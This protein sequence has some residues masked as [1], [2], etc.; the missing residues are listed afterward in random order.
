MVDISKDP[1][2]NEKER[3]RIVNVI[4]PKLKRAGVAIHTI[5]LSKNADH[6]LLKQL[7]TQTDG[8]YQEV[9][10]ADE[11]Q[12][13]FLK[14]FEQA[15]QR[16]A[17][18][19]IDNQFPVD[20]S[21]DEMT[22]LVFRQTD[23]APTRLI[24]PSDKVYDS[25][26]SD[27]KIRWFAT[28][29]Y[30]LI[31]IEKP[32]T[33]NWSIDAKV[34]PDNRVMVVSKLGLSIK[35]LPNNL[36]AGEAIDYQLQLLEEGK[37][38]KNTDFLNLV[39]AILVQDKAGQSS[40]L[41]M[42]YDTTSKTFKQNFFTDS[43]EGELKLTLKV[44]SPTFERERTH[45]INIYGSPIDAEV[46]L[47]E[48]NILPHQLKISAKEDIVD[49]SSLKISLTITQPSGIKKFHVI[50]EA[51]SLTEIAAEVKGGHYK[52]D[53]KIAG[54]SQLGRE[55]SVT[56]ESLEF[57]V[58]GSATEVVEQAVAEPISQSAPAESS[59]KVTQEVPELEPQQTE[60]EQAAE[61]SE[62]EVKPEVVTP[63]QPQEEETETEPPVEGLF[64][65]SWIIIGLGVNFVLAIFGFII[66]R[67][68]KKRSSKAAFGRC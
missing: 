7:S 11:L 27:S 9:N 61:I 33:G 40:K 21:I 55:F 46:I 17:L 52:V 56:P 3:N 23:S 28:K 12:K 29:G 57:D 37:P 66:W 2:V 34:D 8:W 4:L 19:I 48:D 43:F 49:K 59:D 24:S 62:P 42:F 41:A 45:A 38:I 65:V 58:E 68:I 60:P 6:A 18:P 26:S 22:V 20:K 51:D 14:I 32:E 50:D 13:V 35:P 16:D 31:T 15:A 54:K 63:Q 30:D 1:A 53:F 47:S 64:G 44:T 67:V 36:L 25:A 5:A 10:N 39:D